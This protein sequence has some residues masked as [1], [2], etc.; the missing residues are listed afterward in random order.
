MSPQLVKLTFPREVIDSGPIMAASPR[1]MVPWS[2]GC[3]NS[4]A[5]PH[6]LQTHRCALANTG[7]SA[8]HSSPLGSLALLPV[9]GSRKP[10]GDFLLS[11][12]PFPSWAGCPESIPLSC[13]RHTGV[14]GDG[15]CSGV[16]TFLGT[17]LLGADSPKPN[18]DPKQE[19]QRGRAALAK[20]SEPGGLPEPHPQQVVPASLFALL[21]LC[22]LASALSPSTSGTL[23]A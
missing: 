3:C 14:L 20:S 1:T 11:P 13:S 6:T 18:T 23:P 12:P 21:Q 8:P 15:D 16:R 17:W 4:R 5:R 22:P 2:S 9:K 7:I 19:A 10:K